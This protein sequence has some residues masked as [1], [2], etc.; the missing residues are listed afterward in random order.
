MGIGDFIPDPIEHAVEKGTEWVGDRVEDAGDWTAD[1]LDDLG[2]DSG[3]DWVREQSRSVA[4]RMGAQVD[5]MDLGQSD[6]KTKLVYG[7][8]GKLRATAGHL[9]TFQ[10]SFDDVGDGLKGLNSDHLKGEAAEAFRKSVHIQPPKWFTGADAFDAAAKALESFADTVSWAQGQ[11]QTAIDKWK[12]GTKASE[13]AA[14]A[15]KKKVDAYNKAADHYNAQPADKRDPSSLPPKPGSSFPDPGKKLMQDAQDILSE[16]RKQRNAAADTASA[17][18]RAARDKA[19]PKP[20]YTDQLTSGL[21]EVPMMIDH[22][23]GGL[24]KGTAGLNNFARGINP[25]DPYNITHPAEYVTNLDSL[26]AGLV[27]VA[28]D[29]W[30]AGKQMVTDFMKDPSEGLGRLVPDLA[31]TIATDGAGAGVK[32]ARTA[33]ELAD[34]AAAARRARPHD[35]RP[36]GDDIGTAGRKAEDTP[37]ENEPVDVV[38]GAMLMQHTDLTLPAAGLPLIFQRTHLTSYRAGITFGPTWICPLDECVQIDGEGVVFAAADGMR[39]V[40]PVPQPGVPVLPAKGARWP[41]EW[42]GHP[43]GVMTVTDP[44][45]GV[46]RTFTGPMTPSDTPGTYRLLVES[47][48]DRNDTRI[49]LDRD[50]QGLPTALR[51]SGGYHLAIDT[52]GH[53]VT[54]LRLLDHAPSAYEQH[55]PHATAGTVVVRYGYDEAGRLSE[56]INSSGEPLTFEYDDEDRIT[57]WTDRNDTSFQYFY[58]DRG[59]VVRTEGTGGFLSGTFAYDE[60]HRTTAYTDSL[61]HTSRHRYNAEGQVIEDTDA[62]GNTTRTTWEARGD[63][64]LELADALGNTTTCAY[65]ADGHLTTLTLPDGSTAHARHNAFGQPVEVTEPGGARWRRRYDDRGNLLATIDPLGAETHYTYDRAGHLTAVTDALGHVHSF[66]TDKAG[67]PVALTDE[68]GRTTTV[69][70]DIFGRITEVADPLGRTTRTTWTVEGKPKRRAYPDG[71]QEAWTWDA[72]GNLLTHTDRV[73]AVTRHSVTHFDVPATRSDP[74]GRTYT[75]THDTELRLTGVTNPQGLTWSYTYDAAGRLTSE[76]DFNGRTLDYAHDAAGH[77]ILRVNGAGETIR[78]LR[79]ALSR[80]TEQRAETDS[81]TW[82]STFTY[83]AAGH[84]IRTANGDAEIGYERDPLGRVLKETVNRRTTAYVYD[85]LG[86]QIRRT[87]PTGLLSRWT[88]DPAGQPVEL[89][90]DAGFLR[91]GYDAAGR[92]VERNIGTEVLLAHAWNEADRVTSQTLTRHPEPARVGA[93]AAEAQRLLQHR[94]YAYRADG[95]P[96][97]IRDLTSGTLRF[98]LDDAGRVTEVRAHGWRETYRYDTAGNVA[99]ATAPDHASPG[100]RD[101]DGTLIRRAGRTRYEHDSQGRLVRKT[102]KLLDGRRKEWAYVWN[103]EDR[104]VEAVTPEG[105]RWRYAYDPLGRRIGKWVAADG[106]PV[107]ARTEF[108]WD[109]TRL[110]EQTGPDGQALTWDYAPG[111]HRPVAQTDHRPLLKVPGKSALASLAEDT[112]GDHHTRFQAV[113]TDA[114]GAP[115][116]LVTADGKVV[117]HHRTTLWGTDVSVPAA[118]STAHCPLRFPGQYADRETGLHYNYFR[119]YDPETAR[120]LSP[121]PLGLD[122]AP[123]H[124]GYVD[125]PLKYIDPLGLKCKNGQPTDDSGGPKEK[126]LPKYDSFEQARNKALDLLGRIDPATREPYVGRLE[127]AESTYGKVVGFTT[128]VDGE[129]KRFRLDYDPEKGPHINVEVG[130][131]DSA[132]KW[133]VPWNGTEDDFKRIL[134]GNT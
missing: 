15:H 130:K 132:R 87:T 18:I 124:H 4:N 118:D 71:T 70:R 41:L 119:N 64:P 33:D 52:R 88:Y 66:V 43:D 1:R 11:A 22:F 26:A 85:A 100:E 23:E 123:N 31:L 92:E 117:W 19:P 14:D 20:S 47:W 63:K 42:D 34:A 50:H 107:R 58:D 67:L 134:G 84:L 102:L 133:A 16:A 72:E 73:G 121:D 6:D 10:K 24:L 103:P 76:T 44:A 94:A 114:V 113:V 93:R 37:C 21:D 56:V 12:A 68:L 129:F 7:S 106:S 83:D 78:Y 59:R 30:G 110:I 97:E 17:K 3:A 36:P 27:T 89:E 55:D 111:T 128:R 79:D 104:L 51:H 98:S 116:E 91:F 109:D 120:Y 40:Y 99:H 75:F 61:G 90:A 38:T 95:R 35:V 74:D 131:G 60:E 101:F 28:N 29:P 25:L 105:V 9:H 46:V 2:W 45:T 127:S 65:D 53:R 13:D 125:N 108:S 126:V 8:P 112:E 69:R 80:V 49:T 48:H 62:L 122:P 5:E 96:T 77:L 54:A 57:A 81:G 82:N 32:A 86:R 115:A 39:L